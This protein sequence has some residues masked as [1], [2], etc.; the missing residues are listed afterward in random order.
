M[1][2]A[3]LRVKECEKYKSRELDLNDLKLEILPD[4]PDFIKILKCNNNK[5]KY[6]P[7][8]MPDSLQII[9]CYNNKITK[10][11]DKMPD[12]LQ[13]IDCSNNPMAKLSDKMPDSLQT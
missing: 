3:I 1:N 2:I 9:Y 7:N 5:L 10:L 6:L 8:K 12:S 11:P 4:L 13:T